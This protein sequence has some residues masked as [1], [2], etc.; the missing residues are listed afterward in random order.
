MKSMT[1]FGRGEARGDGVT[2]RVECASVN[3]KQLEVSVSVARE[4]GNVEPQVRERVAAM[5]SRGRVNVSIRSENEAGS[6]TTSPVQ[7]NA[8]VMAQYVTQLRAAAESLGL[9]PDLRLGELVRLPGVLAAE[10]SAKDLEALW[11]VIQ[12]ALD[13]ALANLVEM[14][15]VEGGHLREDIEARLRRIDE[16]LAEVGA[17]A[18]QVP[19][20]HRKAMV[21]R[22][23]EAGLPLALDDERIVKEIALF[24]DRSDISEE[25]SR[26]ASHVKK[27][28]DT[29]DSGKPSGRSLDFLLQEFFREFNTMGSKASDAVIAHLVV[30]A[31]TELE[32]IREQ[33]QNV[34]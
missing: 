34:E 30:E 19:E 3:R 28:R 25:L 16:I 26:A 13:A 20:T 17:K 9:S 15:T 6:G 23:E 14:R 31:K 8:E 2:W 5:A 10:E 29:M 27:F 4:L 1:G 7:V 21:Q 11:P 22:L 33:V 12:E 18:S 24:A 32:K